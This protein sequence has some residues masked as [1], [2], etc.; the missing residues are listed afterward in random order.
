MKLT[1]FQ[2]EYIKGMSIFEVAQTL[3]KWFP[4]LQ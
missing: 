4:K 2:M 1:P 3:A